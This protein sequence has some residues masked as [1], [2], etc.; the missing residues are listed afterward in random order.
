MARRSMAE[1]WAEAGAAAR[2]LGKVAVLRPA[3]R[4]VLMLAVAIDR[5]VWR[6]AEVGESL[7][8]SR[9]FRM[10][11][12]ELPW[13]AVQVKRWPFYTAPMRWLAKPSA[14]P[15]WAL[16]LAIVVG[17]AAAGAAEGSAMRAPAPATG[18]VLEAERVLNGV[19]TYADG[20]G[21]DTY[22]LAEGYPGAAM[23]STFADAEVHPT[24]SSGTRRVTMRPR[25]VKHLA[26]IAAGRP[27]T[28]GALDALY[29]ALHETL[30]A[31]G[32]W[33]DREEGVTDAVTADLFR[34]LVLTVFRRPVPW[35]YGV[36]MGYPDQVRLVRAW[37]A[38]ATGGPWRSMAGAVWRRQ[39]LEA[40]EATRD[41]MVADANAKAAAR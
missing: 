13:P 2:A 29:I 1:E 33:G 15:R 19:A 39:L 41:R 30:H 8:G 14:L 25:H 12:F 27:V 21:A 20:A 10:R 32:P 35:W 5:L 37:S 26:A 31:D 16:I 24:D 4:L 34:G 9:E 17:A 28:A 23:V 3:L 7:K 38:A 18:Y 22:R 36:P 6:Q 40:D 11:P